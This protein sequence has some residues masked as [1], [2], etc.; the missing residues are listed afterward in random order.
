MH[1]V[2][3][4]QHQQLQKKLS[5]QVTYLRQQ[6]D[7]SKATGE[8][9]EVVHDRSSTVFCP[10][11]ELDLHLDELAGLLLVLALHGAHFIP[12]LLTCG[13][14]VDNTLIIS[15]SL[16]CSKYLFYNISFTII[17]LLSSVTCVDQGSSH[18]L[19]W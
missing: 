8:V 18:I 19:L 11:V 5:P 16:D 17:E 13:Q 15:Q 12:Q 4:T 6:L 3:R 7:F 14:D 2:M 10:V 1:F 9:L